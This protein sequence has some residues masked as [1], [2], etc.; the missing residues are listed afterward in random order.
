MLSK[1]T[2]NGV[3]VG[4]TYVCPNQT[5]KPLTRIKVLKEFN[6]G[7]L[8]LIMQDQTGTVKGGVG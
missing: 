8:S 3:F 2:R 6:P 7:N 4:A 5:L 1:K